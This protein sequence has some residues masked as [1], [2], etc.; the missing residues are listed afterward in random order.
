MTVDFAGFYTAHW[1]RL[2]RTTYAVTQDRQL[3]ED[4]LQTAFARAHARWPRVSRADDPVAYVRRIAVN[5]ALAQHRKAHRRHETVADRLPEPAS[6]G[7]TDAADDRLAVRDEVWTAVAALPPAQR[8]VVVLR[9][10][11]DLSERQ[12]AEVLRCRPGTVKSRAAT[13]L[14]TLRGSLTEAPTTRGELR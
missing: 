12:I 7:T 11:E 3:A 9:Y 10:Y 14:A 5:A 1:P 4:A 13:A 6:S 8:A 2:L